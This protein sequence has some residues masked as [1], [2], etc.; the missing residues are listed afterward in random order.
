META[1]Q[2]DS[3][4]D[5]LLGY[6]DPNGNSNVSGSSLSTFKPVEN[7]SKETAFFVQDDWKV[8]SNLTL[9]LGLRY[10]WSTPY[11]ERNNLIQ[12]SNFTGDSGIAVPINVSRPRYSIPQAQSPVPTPV[13]LNRTGDLLGTTNFPTSGRRNSPVDRNNVAPRF[14]FAYA[15]NSNTVIRGGAGVYYG[16][17]PATNF[18]FTGPAFGNSNA[19]R[20]TKDDFQTPFATLATPFPDAA[21]TPGSISYAPPQGI[22][23]APTP[24][25]VTPI[26]IA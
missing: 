26:T 19:I 16:L 9:N 7:K 15:L 23:T 20:F 24:C 8:N 14:G 4:A 13:L 10:E 25:G 22:N 3:Y 12:F 1:Q 2:G 6:G 17:N 21:A 18:Q 5:L 11:T